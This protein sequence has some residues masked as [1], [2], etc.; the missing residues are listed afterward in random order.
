MMLVR[1]DGAVGDA[2]PNHR[3]LSLQ[4]GGTDKGQQGQQCPVGLLALRQ[5]P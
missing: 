2:R 5:E 3:P 4:G 1:E